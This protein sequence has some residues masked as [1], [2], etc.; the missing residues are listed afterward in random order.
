MSELLRKSRYDRCLAAGAAAVAVAIGV[1]LPTQSSEARPVEVVCSGSE[2]VIVEKNDTLTDL[3]RKN[4]VNSDTGEKLT[5]EEAFRV[6]YVYK[7]YIRGNEPM[8]DLMEVSSLDVPAHND[9]RLPGLQMDESIVL[10]ADCRTD[11]P[12]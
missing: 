1:N 5:G 11:I 8:P 10:P 2:G 6:A 12:A 4:S 7:D 9:V 3:I